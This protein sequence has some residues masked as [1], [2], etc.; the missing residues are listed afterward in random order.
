MG[1][2]FPNHNS[3]VF[4]GRY[5]YTLDQKGRLSIPSNFREVLRR[6]YEEEKLMLTSLGKSLV[7]YPIP[8]W[9]IIEEKVSR[10]PQIKPEV[11][12]FQLL[13]ISSAVECEFD[14][15]GRILVPSALREEAGLQKEV[16]IAGMLNRFE[17]WDKQRWDEE[18]KSLTENFEE[19]A[20]VLSDLG[21]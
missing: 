9:L 5:L 21:I 20:K 16:V 12:K 15:Q 17:I 3:R 8:E 6:R 13:F 19:I 7:A 18:M 1:Q 14:K 11:R 4:R 10:L 2:T